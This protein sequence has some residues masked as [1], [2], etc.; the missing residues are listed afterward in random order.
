MNSLI[1]YGQ[2][3]TFKQCLPTILNYIDYD[4][5][6]YDVFLLIDKN[7]DVN[8]NEENMILL[9]NMLL[10]TNIKMLKYTNEMTQEEI[11]IENDL[12]N[13]YNRTCEVIKKEFDFDTII[14][15]KFVTKLYYRRYLLLSYVNDYCIN[16]NVHY[17][18]CILTRFDI[19]MSNKFAFP[20]SNKMDN[21]SIM[22]D[23]FFSGNLLMLLKIF[24]F[25]FDYFA[26]Y[27][28]YSEKDSTVLNKL[29]NNTQNKT[30]NK[31]ELNDI[32]NKWFC[33][34]EINFY[35]YLLHKNIKFN[36]IDCENNILR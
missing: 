30:L 31:N 22:F 14:T 10:K 4:N 3:R 15:N 6:K 19:K 11:N 12:L 9:E 5:K 28:V 35:I 26:M 36:L 17:D 33:M 34:P 29:L 2:L 27:D 1:I 25:F 21:L 32:Y 16:N 23:I 20:K 13:K 7:N 8:Y 18:N 24:Q